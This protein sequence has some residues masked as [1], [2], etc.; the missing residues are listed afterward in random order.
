M[1]PGLA[2]FRSRTAEGTA[3]VITGVLD[4]ESRREVSQN[5]EV[6]WEIKVTGAVEAGLR[7]ER[8]DV[9]V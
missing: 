1:L 4:E 5:H 2:F 8:G 7:D 3:M 6:A 9:K